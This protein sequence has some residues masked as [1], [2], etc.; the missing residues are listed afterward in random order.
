MFAFGTRFKSA[1][2][3]TALSGLFGTVLWTVQYITLNEG[4]SVAVFY[5]NSQKSCAQFLKLQK[6]SL[7]IGKRTSTFSLFVFNIKSRSPS[8]VFL[9]ITSFA[10]NALAFIKQIIGFHISWFYARS[11]KPADILI[12]SCGK[13]GTTQKPCRFLHFDF[14]RNYFSGPAETSALPA[15][16]PSYFAKFFINLSA[17]S[18]AFSSQT[19][20]SE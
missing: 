8:V 1:Y 3:I 9:I 14:C 11:V 4:L 17:R 16:L 15:S 20:G 12:S 10:L 13:S 6:S 7:L 2:L 5:L 19:A 18:F